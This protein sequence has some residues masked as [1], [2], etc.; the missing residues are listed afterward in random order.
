MGIGVQLI[1]VYILNRKRGHA[2]HLN[3]GHRSTKV[4]SVLYE[5]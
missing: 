2:H 5:K 1:E 4:S 3:P